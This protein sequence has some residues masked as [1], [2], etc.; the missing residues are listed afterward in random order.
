MGAISPA[1]FAPL[2]EGS[3]LINLL[4]DWIFKRVDS[5]ILALDGAMPPELTISIN[6]SPLQFSQANF[7]ETLKTRLAQLQSNNEIELE[8]TEGVVMSDAEDSMTKLMELRSA[9]FRLA[10]DDFGT[11]YSSLSYL[12]DFPVNTL[13]IDQAFVAALGTESANSIVRAI[14]ALAKALNL[15]VVAEG[16]ETREQAAF[17]TG[18]Q[19]KIL[20]G[21]LLARPMPL[22]GVI[23]LLDHDF[24]S[25][26]TAT[27]G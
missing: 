4:G 26:L 17:L 5:D 19:C 18:H 10:I 12:K 6:L 23:D 2:A 22:D 25:M 8:L 21:F 14:L 24:S 9:G 27:T 1:V 3:G 20:Q 16:V 13:K 11:G 7:L 15:D